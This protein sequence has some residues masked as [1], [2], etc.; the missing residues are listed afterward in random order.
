MIVEQHTVIVYVQFGIIHMYMYIELLFA[1]EE[2]T[3]N[4]DNEQIVL[5]QNNLIVNI[6][7]VPFL[8]SNFE[9]CNEKCASESS[10][11]T[12]LRNESKSH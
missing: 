5:M 4:V 1:M 7:F 10:I 11:E 8:I 12:R 2:V 6:N 9:N 3:V